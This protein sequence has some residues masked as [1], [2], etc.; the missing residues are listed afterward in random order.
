MCWAIEEATAGYEA[1][2]T[3]GKL[4]YVEHT[5]ILNPLKERTTLLRRSD[6]S[7]RQDYDEG[8]RQLHAR[9]TSAIFS[10]DFHELVPATSISRT[11]LRF[12]QC[13]KRS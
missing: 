2:L 9:Q 5:F 4:N 11:L 3:G 7:E 10:S 6:I 8:R 13:T 12:N 1:A